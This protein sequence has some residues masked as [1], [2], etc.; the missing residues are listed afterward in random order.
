MVLHWY[1]EALANLHSEPL[2]L[3]TMLKTPNALYIVHCICK[4]IP[5]PSRLKIL[6]YNSRTKTEHT[7][8]EEIDRV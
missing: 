1:H 3:F 8:T 2:S 4:Y 7:C 6:Q 5:D